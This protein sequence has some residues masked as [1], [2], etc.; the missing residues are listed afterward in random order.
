MEESSLTAHVVQ[1]NCNQGLLGRFF[2]LASPQ[3]SSCLKAVA[4]LKNSQSPHNSSELYNEILNNPI[5]SPSIESSIKQIELD[6]TRTC[7]EISYFSIGNGEAVLRRI[8]TAYALYD[9]ELGYVQGM[10]FIVGSFMWHASESDCFWLLVYLMEDFELREVFLPRLPGVAKHCQ[11]I[12][13]LAFEALP[14][15]YRM[16]AEYR[17]TSEMYAAEWCISL[18]SSI[19][20]IPEMGNMLDLFFQYG[21][22]FFYKL[23]IAVLEWL[24][25]SLI[26]TR[27]Y[28]EFLCSLRINSDWNEKVNWDGLLKRASLIQLDEKFIRSLHMSFNLET[29]QFS[30][31]LVN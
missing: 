18:F 24:E 1:C 4:W 27:N 11:I 2:H 12:Q 15:L 3:S 22:L 7:P 21:W 30:I 29:A 16:F 5:S 20:P 17:I 9:S 31:R 8:L 13:L 6:V 19:V 25:T 26:K 28:M 10:N 23:G 14:N